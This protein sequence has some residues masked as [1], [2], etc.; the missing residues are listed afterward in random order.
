MPMMTLM[1]IEMI[2]LALVALWVNLYHLWPDFV[3]VIT[4]T[5]RVLIRTTAVPVR[6]HKYHYANRRH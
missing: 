6:Q 4:S 2:A 5:R 1:V 3:K